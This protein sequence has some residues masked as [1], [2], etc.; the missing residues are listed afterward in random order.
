FGLFTDNNNAIGSAV[1]GKSCTTALDNSNPPQATCTISNILPP[2]TYWLRETTTPAGFSSA[3]DTKISIAL[4]TTTQVTH[5][6]PRQPGGVQPTDIDDVP[7]ALSAELFGLFT[8]NNDAIGS[9]VAGKS[10]TT[11][12]DNSNPPQAT[13]TISGILPAGTYWLHE[14]TVPAGF[15]PA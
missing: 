14:T 5:A 4:N 9:A 10:C 12:L 2:G 6:D 7:P 3:A 13:C 1:A 8:D 15:D 11:A